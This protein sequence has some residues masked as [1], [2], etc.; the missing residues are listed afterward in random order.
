MFKIF[1]ASR[2]LLRIIQVHPCQALTSLMSST[3]RWRKVVQH[4]LVPKFSPLILP[5][6]GLK[7]HVIQF[8]KAPVEYP[9][10]TGTEHWRRKM[11]TF[12]RCF[13]VNGDC[14]ITKEDFVISAKRIADYMNLNDERAEHMLNQRIAMWDSTS[15]MKEG[16]SKISEEEYLKSAP[17][18]FNQI[19]YR[20]EVFPLHVS[21]HFTALD[22]D[23]DGLISRDEHKASA[24]SFNIPEEESKKI[25]DLLD[26]DKSGFI[27]IDEIAHGLAEFFFTEDPK[28][29]YNVIFGP[30]AD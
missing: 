26:I 3:Q 28:N 24:Y 21:M 8:R 2:G 15:K 30:L 4:G 9:P 17:M 16:A 19:S 20:H 25:F 12:F 27:T 14:Y 22:L 5:A 7:N 1:N 6:R 10:V 29:K 13:D 23:S 11:R 18:V